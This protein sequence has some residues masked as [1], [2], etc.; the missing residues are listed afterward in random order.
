MLINVS[1]GEKKLDSGLAMMNTAAGCEINEKKDGIRVELQKTEFEFH[2]KFQW[3]FD[4][5]KGKLVRV[6]WE[7]ELSEFE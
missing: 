6:S 7:F 3:N 4:Q 1:F 5:G 2:G